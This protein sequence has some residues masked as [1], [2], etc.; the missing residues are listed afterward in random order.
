MQTCKT[1]CKCSDCKVRGGRHGVCNAWERLRCEATRIISCCCPSSEFQARPIHGA[2][3]PPR[4]AERQERELSQQRR[5]TLQADAAAPC[6]FF[7]PPQVAISWLFSAPS[8]STSRSGLA[9]G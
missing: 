9:G 8:G 7:L 1:C 5:N 4:S 3:F 2:V 6:I